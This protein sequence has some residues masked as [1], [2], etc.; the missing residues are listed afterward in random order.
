M[1]NGILDRDELHKALEALLSGKSNSAD[2]ELQLDLAHSGRHVIAISVARMPK[3]REFHKGLILS[4]EDITI[5][6]SAEIM[7]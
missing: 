4:L 7:A 5:C 3:V 2:V 6:K 1:A